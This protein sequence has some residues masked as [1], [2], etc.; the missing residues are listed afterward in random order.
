MANRNVCQ[1]GL[2]VLPLLN[3][4]GFALSK[5]TVCM[6]DNQGAMAICKSNAHHKRS[7][8]SRVACHYLQEL[9]LDQ[10]IIC[11]WVESTGLKADILTKILPER[12]HNAPQAEITEFRRRRMSTTVDNNGGELLE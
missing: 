5:A 10:I 9:Y 1:Q 12:Q 6:Q 11:Q 4:M 3:D 8:H 7:G 2:C